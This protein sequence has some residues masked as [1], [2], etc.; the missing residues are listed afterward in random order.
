MAPETSTEASNRAARRPVTLGRISGLY[1]IRGW[2]KVTSYTEPRGALLDYKDCLVGQAG[3]GWKQVTSE[4]AYERSGPERFLST[5]PIVERCLRL[6]LEAPAAGSDAAAGRLLARLITLRNMS[7][8]IWGALEA[9]LQPVDLI[10]LG[11]L[12]EGVWPG[13]TRTDPWLSRR[14]RSAIGLPPPERRIGLAAHD[15]AAA[16]GAPRVIL[17]RAEKRGGAP[18]VMSRWLQRLTAITGRARA[19]ALIAS[20]NEQRAMLS[21]SRSLNWYSW[22]AQLRSIERLLDFDFRWVLPGH[23]RAHSAESPSAMRRELERALHRLRAA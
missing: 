4:L 21:A 1:G 7:L 22:D 17:S 12:D 14:M 13:E 9:R 5:M 19:D 8:A 15:F 11:A 2:V 3:D 6:V 23:G 16:M 18:T 10:I 20:W